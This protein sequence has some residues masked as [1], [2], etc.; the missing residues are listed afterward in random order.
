MPPDAKVLCETPT[1]DKSAKRIDRWKYDV[2]RKAILATLPRRGAGVLFADLP[3]LVQQQLSPDERKRLG[4]VDW[5]TTTVKLALEV[6]G[7]IHR[8]KGAVPQRLLRK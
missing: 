8:V 3:S 4:S 7:E 5:Y 2:V 6:K 1:P